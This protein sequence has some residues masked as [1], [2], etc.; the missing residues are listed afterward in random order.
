MKTLQ[1]EVALELSFEGV[2]S[3][4]AEKGEGM[5]SAFQAKAV[6][7]R[8]KAQVLLK[9]QVI[10]CSQSLR[11]VTVSGRRR[12]RDAEEGQTGKGLIYQANQLDFF[13]QL[14]ITYTYQ[15]QFL[16]FIKYLQCTRQGVLHI[17]LHLM[18]FVYTQEK[19]LKRGNLYQIRSL[20]LPKDYPKS[21]QKR[22][23]SI[24]IPRL[25]ISNNLG[26]FPSHYSL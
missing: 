21:H 25:L 17:L 23:P 19:S 26:L 18:F 11:S 20:S 5:K 6:V 3:Q 15:Q 4:K 24:G 14:G 10:V 7:R 1:Q 13:P 22:I 12:M 16:Y 2:G 8:H 9:R